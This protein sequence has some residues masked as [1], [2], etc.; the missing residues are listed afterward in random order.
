M[1]RKEASAFL[2][3]LLAE[4]KL[5]S[6]SFV[7][8]EPNPKEAEALSTGYKIRI[9]TILES[10]CRQ[11]IKEITKKYDLAVIEELNQII[12][13]KPKSDRS[14]HLILK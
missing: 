4:C 8:L 14:D 7:L 12:V 9:K 3:E 11:R 1:N 6:D 13:Y 2:K 10:E 5:D